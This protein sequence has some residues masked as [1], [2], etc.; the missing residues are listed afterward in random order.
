LKPKAVLAREHGPQCPLP[1]RYLFEYF[2]EI[3][4]GLSANG[5]SIPTVSWESL[6]AWSGLRGVDLEPWESLL[7]VQLGQV[8]AKALMEK[9]TADK[10]RE[11]HV[12]Q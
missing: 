8:R 3:A 2:Q 7:L 10:D 4:I 1:L 5:F 12:S 6:C 11:Q 9:T